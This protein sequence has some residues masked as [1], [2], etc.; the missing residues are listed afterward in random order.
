MRAGNGASASGA[1][2][3]ARMWGMP[4][5]DA[6]AWLNSGLD[7]AWVR[8]NA[9][10]LHRAHLSPAAAKELLAH[11]DE[12]VA[13]DIGRLI[14]AG[15][16]ASLDTRWLHWWATSGLL[17]PVTAEQSQPR[18]QGR[19]RRP[20]PP[21]PPSFTRWVTEA[22]KFIGATDG[23][24][25]LAALFA[26]AGMSVEETATRFRD[27]DY[28]EDALLLLARMRTPNAPGRGIAL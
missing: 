14:N 28:D 8:A 9:K 6:E 11:I 5:P 3:F 21:P 27:G 1:A 24:Q 2:A 16:M 10:V 18:T 12:S 20:K 7:R 19:V 4:V 17:R 26:A 22:R 25:R 23:D 15:N 13:G